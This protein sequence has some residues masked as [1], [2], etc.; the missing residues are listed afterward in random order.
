MF[1]TISKFREGQKDHERQPASSRQ[2]TELSQNESK[3]C[4]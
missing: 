1:Q 3:S 4:I 2:Q